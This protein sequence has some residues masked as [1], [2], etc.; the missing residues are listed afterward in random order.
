MGEVVQTIPTVGKHSLLGLDWIS[1]LIMYNTKGH[2]IEDITV[3]G[4]TVHMWDVGGKK[5]V[6]VTQYQFIFFRS[7]DNRDLVATLMGNVCY[8]R[9]GRGSVGVGGGL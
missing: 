6:S 3:S 5:P 7:T 2:Y 4:V 9:G 1:N 8:R